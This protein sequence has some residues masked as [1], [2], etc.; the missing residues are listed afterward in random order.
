MPRHPGAVRG[1]DEVHVGKQD[2][3]GSFLLV[4]GE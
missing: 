4:F 3:T 2:P 1:N